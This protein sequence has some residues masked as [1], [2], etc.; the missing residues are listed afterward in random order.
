[1]FIET[2]LGASEAPDAAPSKAR[3]ERFARVPRALTNDARLGAEA[4]ALAAFVR[5]HVGAWEVNRQN[6][7]R[8]GAASYHGFD[9]A[10]R[11]LVDAGYLDR[12]QDR[13][14]GCVFA[15]AVAKWNWPTDDRVAVA[16]ASWFTLGLRPKLIGAAIWLRANP[17]AFRR[18]LADRFD[19]GATASKEWLAE[20]ATAGIIEK[21]RKSS[22]VAY[23]IRDEGRKP[24]CGDLA[25]RKPQGGK[26]QSRN[27]QSVHKKTLHKRN[28]LTK[29]SPSGANFSFSDAG[30]RKNKNGK[31]RC[32][33][34][35]HAIAAAG[36]TLD[37]LGRELLDELAALSCYKADNA[38]SLKLL[39][40]EI[41]KIDA[42]D[43]SAVLASFR[44]ARDLHARPSPTTLRQVAGQ[45]RDARALRD[46]LAAEIGDLEAERSGLPAKADRLD[47]EAADAAL[48]LGVDLAAERADLAASLRRA[49]EGEAV[50]GIV[51]G[52]RS[53]FVRREGSAFD[54]SAI[55]DEVIL[56]AAKRRERS[57]DLNGQTIRALE[58]LS[59][60]FV[61][62]GEFRRCIQAESTRLDGQIEWRRESLGAPEKTVPWPMP[63]FTK[64]G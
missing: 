40:V 59:G 44:S 9:R 3:A 17:G 52:G 60:Q 10:M 56:W 14:E 64:K 19:L 35:D 58:K 4:I 20:L 2:T 34:V 46:R 63:T 45:V 48:A 42:A 53:S 41:S 22:A 23:S 15:A 1:M 37:Q 11:Q 62:A 31:R 54:L 28:P 61:A 43:I 18:E 21:V 8:R 6:A 57:G 5:L 32:G 26:P 13:T 12:W 47:A 36:V 55:R 39:T 50:P 30:T 24:Q 33:A 27:P 51:C 7:M 49:S 29:E 25:G 38:A 16:P